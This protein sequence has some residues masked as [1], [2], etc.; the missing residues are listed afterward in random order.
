MKITAAKTEIVT[1]PLQR[2]ITTA[3]HSIDSLGCVLLRLESDQDLL[4][5]SYLFA[6]NGARIKAFDEML[7]GLAHLVVGRNPHHVSAIWHD[8]WTEINPSGHKGITVA[9]LSTI[10]TACWDLIGKAL[11]APLHHI[12]GAC[13]DRVKTYAS[14][15]LW[16]TQSIDE[17]IADA[18]KFVHD[19]F[20]AIKMRGG[21]ATIAEDVARVRA[22]RE[23]IEPNIELMFDLNQ[24]LSP[25]QAI[26]LGRE[27][28]EFQLTWIE[29]PVAAYNLTGHAQVTARLDT[30]IASGETEYTSFGMRQ[31]IEAQAC[32][33][34]T[35]DLQ[36]IG[37]LS[38]MMR[39][40]ALAAAH[41]IPISTHMFTEQSL[42]IAGAAVNCMSVEYMPWFSTLFNEELE[43]VD[44]ELIIPQRPGTG[45]T[46][47]GS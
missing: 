15:G 21:C 10:D 25:K 39:T 31:M 29:E 27:L 47:T 5:E 17:L 1:L 30:P 22:V 20:R 43:L 16:L 42:C 36:R 9:A 41:N 19:G 32:D 38:E 24:A 12:F 37:G 23:A 7:R 3:I 44:G 13:R 26:R 45:F 8:I 2:P 4:G 6:L 18:E 46:F 28:E 11:N 35:P 40:A 34:L 33:I 14:G